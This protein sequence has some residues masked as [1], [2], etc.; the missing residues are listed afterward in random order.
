MA[1]PQVNNINASKAET[2]YMARTSLSASCM[3]TATNGR[4]RRRIS[5]KTGE[6]DARERVGSARDR[7]V[8]VAQYVMASRYRAPTLL[9]THIPRRDRKAVIPCR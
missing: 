4:G 2:G 6:S 9:S 7:T 8:G 3:G 5:G 1:A